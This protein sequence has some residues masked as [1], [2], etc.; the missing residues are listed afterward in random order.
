M[1][2]LTVLLLLW[3]NKMTTTRILVVLDGLLG[4]VCVAGLVLALTALII[5]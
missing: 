2:W 3:V 1:F 4:L 5:G